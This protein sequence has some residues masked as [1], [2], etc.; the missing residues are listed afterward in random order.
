MLMGTLR[1]TST[2]DAAEMFILICR[3]LF[4]SLTTS[5]FK[6][7]TFFVKSKIENVP[8]GIQGEKSS[9]DMANSRNRNEDLHLCYF[10]FFFVYFGEKA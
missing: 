2:T 1:S 5:D 9:K 10:H 3:F 6:L 4:S 7:L 8:R